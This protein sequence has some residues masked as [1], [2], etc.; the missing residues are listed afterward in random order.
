MII[1]EDTAL[2]TGPYPVILNDNEDALDIAVPEGDQIEE[3]GDAEGADYSIC[4]ENR[5]VLRA[6]ARRVAE[7]AGL[8]VSA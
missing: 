8:Q 6:W 7:L 2:P 5:D 1:Y 3:A 4:F